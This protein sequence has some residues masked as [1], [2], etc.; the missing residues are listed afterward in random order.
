MSRNIQN[1]INADRDIIEFRMQAE[2]LIN[3][4]ELITDKDFEEASKQISDAID[5]RIKELYQIIED[6][7]KQ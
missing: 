1:K 7:A 4:I 3:N 5:N 6:Q 2:E